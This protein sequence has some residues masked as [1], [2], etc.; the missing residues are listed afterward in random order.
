M[1]IGPATGTGIFTASLARTLTTMRSTSDNLQMQLNT[2][3]KS[4]D[5]AGLGSSRSVS[6]SLRTQLSRIDT[7]QSSIE[8]VD[9]RLKLMDTNLTRMAAITNEVKSA[10]DPTEFSIVSNGQTSSQVASRLA[11]DEMI[12]LLNADVAGRYLFSGST[13]DKEPVEL[14]DTILNGAGTR[15]GLKQVIQERQSADL[16]ADG[17]GRLALTAPAAP[18]ADTF[19]LAEDGDH[20]FGFKMT[21]ITPNTPWLSSTALTPAPATT[22]LTVATVPNV[23]DTVRFSFDLPDGTTHELTLT[24]TNTNPPG[25]NQFLISQGENIGNNGLGR[26]TSPQVNGTV[27]SFGE[28][29]SHDYG[30]K[31]NAVAQTGGWATLA[32]PSGTPQSVSLN[33]VSQPAAGDTFTVDLDLPTGGTQTVTLTASGALPLA[34]G[35]FLIGA[36]TTA[37]AENL[38]QSLQAELTA[39]TAAT[40]APNVEETAF[41]LHAA[42]EKSLKYTADTALKA[43]SNLQAGTDFFGNPPQRIGTAPFDT[44]TTLVDGTAA[45]TVF[46]YKGDPSTLNARSS[47]TARI[48]DTITLNYGARANENAFM[49]ALR[50]MAVYAS[51]SFSA[52]DEN[53]FENHAAL[54]TRV[55]ANLDGKPGATTVANVGVEIGIAYAQMKQTSSRHTVAANMLTNTLADSEQVDKQEVAAKILAIQNNLQASYQ[56]TANMSSLRLVNFL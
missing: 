20:P 26:L 21:A 44:A 8:T 27:V 34:P 3:L 18:T 2:G 29:G 14:M 10:A 55:K 49:D 17:L 38:R 1:P 19:T 37:T 42:F 15:V 5:F 30:F 9:L 54:A 51:V 48:D 39:T 41:N 36:D 31:L 12:E 52:T 46:W 11:L 22:D 40:F 43:A 35:E 32:G 24:A 33:V 7:Y 28:D 16:G 6:L 23:G 25:E 53:A 56:V 50:N 13:T 47:V 45:D 4:Q